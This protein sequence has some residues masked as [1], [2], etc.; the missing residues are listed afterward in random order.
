MQNFKKD[1]GRNLLIVRKAQNV[2]HLELVKQSGL[3]RPIIS[4]IENGSANPTFESLIKLSS[5]LN[6]NL[7]MLL[8]SKTKFEILKKELFSCF[9]KDSNSTSNLIIPEKYWKN[10]LLMSGD[11]TAKNAVKVSKIIFEILKLNNIESRFI[12]NIILGAT[13]GVIFQ[14]DGFE[15][16]LNFGIWLGEKIY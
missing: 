15:K 7:E 9:E 4:T 5:S 2:S 14:K 10:L 12:G 13:L 16:G 6:V 1:I 3:T 11:E 8:L